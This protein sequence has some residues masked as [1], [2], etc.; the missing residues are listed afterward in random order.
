MTEQTRVNLHCHSTLSDGGLSPDELAVLLSDHGVRAA[1]LTDHDSIDGIEDFRKAAARKGMGSITG[2]EISAQGPDGAE[3][4][5]L[6]YGFDPGNAAL[7]EALRRLRSVNRQVPPGT[8]QE[9]WLQPGGE[10]ARRATPSATIPVAEAIALL[11]AANGIAVLAHPVTPGQDLRVEAIDALLTE[12]KQVGLD[13]IEAFYCGYSEETRE[14]L[15]AL[16]EKH[17]LL[18]S[19]GSD[20]HAV[21]RPGLCEPGIEMP[22]A[23]WRQFRDAVIETTSETAEAAAK[24]GVPSER[25]FISPWSSFTLRIVL[26]T[27]LA[28]ALFVFAI[29][30][31]IIPAFE[32]RLLDRKREM[33]R[34][35]T[36]L[37]CGILSESDREVRAGRLSLAQAQDMA[38]RRIGALRYGKE[39]KDYF[40]LMDTHPRMVSHPYVPELDGQDLT[41]FKDQ[42]GVRIFVEFV[43]VLK[44]SEDGYV[45]YVWQWKDDPGRLAPKQSYIKKFAPWDWIVG[46]GLYVEDV[47]NEIKA[48]ETRMVHV[49]LGITAVSALLLVFVAL[50]SMTIERRR[51]YAEDEL[52]ESHEKYRTLVEAATDGILMVL[53]GR[54]TYANRTMAEML[55]YS[56]ADFALLDLAD[57]FPEDAGKDSIGRLLSEGRP[58]PPLCESRLR[59]KGGDTVEVAITVT[60]IS[61][62]GRSG[63]ILAARDLDTRKPGEPDRRRREIERENLIAELQASLMFLHEPVSACVTEVVSCEMREPISRAVEIMTRHGASAILITSGGET[64]GIVTDR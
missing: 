41:D 5:V 20:F 19:A 58:I 15:L 57:F 23:L 2:V 29:Y 7:C 49:S 26:P 30:W 54:C 61:S 3:L 14:A 24:A 40:W 34:E 50:Q 51:R 13:G 6:G 31:I 35:L 42:R 46:T 1:A 44:T 33:I 59:T 4:H 52:R 16:A 45:E 62:A 18:V 53:D 48:M 32:A 37:A 27:F 55:G 12:L 17:G 63:F 43:N 36:N 56:E 38:A 22:T 11:H 47:R 21:S 28:I 60:P 10:E 39:G 9:A 25:R 8:I 64:T